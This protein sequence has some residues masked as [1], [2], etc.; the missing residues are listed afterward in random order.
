M[1][2]DLFAL[3]HIDRVHGAGADPARL[4]LEK[5]NARLE[6]GVLVISIQDWDG[7]VGAGVK[8]LCS[9][10]FLYKSNIL[11][12]SNMRQMNKCI[13]GKISFSSSRHQI[14]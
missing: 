4:V 6:L 10:H 12:M 1:V 2:A 11:N 3:C 8:M 9:V 14:I 13:L 7:D 5:Q